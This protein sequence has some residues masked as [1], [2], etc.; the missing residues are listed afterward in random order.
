[1]FYVTSLVLTYFMTGSLYLLKIEGV[2][3]SP[4][5]HFIHSLQLNE[6]LASFW[7]APSCTA[8]WKIPPH[9]KMVP[10]QGPV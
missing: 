8:V 1:M 3:L 2:S 10:L 6:L 7:V 4:N 5:S 9:S